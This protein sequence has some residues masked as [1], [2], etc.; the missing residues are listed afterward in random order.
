[1]VQCPAVGKHQ[2]KNLQKICTENAGILMNINEYDCWD[3]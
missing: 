2:I 3:S 1:M